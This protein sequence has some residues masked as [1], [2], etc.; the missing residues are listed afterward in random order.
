MDRLKGIL[1][2]YGHTLVWF[3][4][5]EEAHVTAAKNVRRVLCDLG[6]TV[7]V[8]RVRALIESYVPRPDG[9]SVS[10]EEEAKGIL[11]SA[12][13]ESF[14]QRD[15]R[16]IIDA[17]WKPYIE[18]VRLRKGVREFLAYSKERGLKL[19]IVANIWSGGMIPVLKK[20]GIEDF[21]D[22]RVA[23]MDVGFA[24]PDPR[25][26]RLATGNLQLASEQ[27]VMVGDNPKADIRGAHDLGMG[28]IRL[29]RGPN[30]AQPDCVEVDFKV[31]DFSILVSIIRSLTD[32]CGCITR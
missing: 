4:K 17:E 25:I 11:V 2:D 32:V 9:T 24:K 14:D 18:N 23:S 22:T 16:R 8:S 29:I 20:L 31:N 30:R 5:Y 27:V 10:V 13:V 26:F 15:L 28:T 19:G 6:V 1:F 21:F 12:G 3:P 7:E